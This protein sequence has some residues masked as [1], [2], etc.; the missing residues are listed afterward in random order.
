MLDFSPQD[1]AR[2]GVLAEA[3]GLKLSLF[4]QDPEVL[5]E[6][7][8]LPEELRERFALQALRIGVLALRQASGQ[9]DAEA[10]KKAGEGVVRELERVVSEDIRGEFEK[11]LREYLKQQD[12]TLRKNLGQHMGAESP[13]FK[14]L[15][16]TDAAGV[17]QQLKA[18]MDRLLEERQQKIL[19]QF[20]LDNGTSALSRL[21]HRV[22]Q[23]NRELHEQ[24]TGTI[25]KAAKDAQEFQT[26]VR[27]ALTA[28]QTKK[29]EAAKSTLQGKDFE[30]A[31]GEALAL[32]AEKG[33]EIFTATGAQPG[34]I[35]FNKKGD[36]VTEMGP[37]HVAQGAKI[38]W[39]AKS[40]QAFP[41]KEALAELEEARKNRDAQVGI[42]VY[43]TKS[44]SAP[45]Q[46]LSRYGNDLVV[47]WDSEDRSTDLHLQAALCVARALLVR[48]KAEQQDGN[49]IVEG[50][51]KAAGEI[52]RQ[53]A[54]LGDIKTWASTIRSNGEKIEDKA[55][56]M[57]AALEAE[58]AAVNGQIA[59]LKT[60]A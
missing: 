18:S 35:K 24:L 50:L 31:L 54:G 46:I 28:I 56:K 45:A 39:E 11:A 21:V 19:E 6:L 38:V 2:A 60:S 58:I 33:G 52:E 55:A 59:A 48:Q 23:T 43:S 20:S 1:G 13:I 22:Q 27:E 42:F 57:K 8:K 32:E 49:K 9:V 37:E 44:P 12:E 29:T 51:A 14:A 34:L 16:P 7:Q 30:A 25:E 17:Q 41:L 10:I 15:S 3:A 5:A 36:Y 4:V 40:A 47:S 53:L 26:Q